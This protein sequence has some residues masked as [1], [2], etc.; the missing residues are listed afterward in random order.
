MTG[1]DGVLVHVGGWFPSIIV[2]FVVA[3]VFNWFCNAWA[4]IRAAV[5]ATT[6]VFLTSSNEV[7][8]EFSTSGD[9]ILAWNALS[10]DCSTRV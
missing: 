1:W 3:V 8:V 2:P 6:A 4:V 5:A 10:I 9:V 7:D